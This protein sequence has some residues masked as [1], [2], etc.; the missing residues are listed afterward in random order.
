MPI[1]MICGVI[2]AFAISAFPFTSGFVTVDGFLSAADE[3][4]FYV[5]LP[6][7]A[8][9]AGVSFMLELN[10]HG[11]FFSKGFWHAPGSTGQ[12]ETS[13]VYFVCLVHFV[14]CVPRCDIFN[15]TL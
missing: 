5:W 14:G 9:S 1:T 13:N 3:H 4:L 2:G 7:S 11:L 8:A 10:F 6:S 15:L 12:Y